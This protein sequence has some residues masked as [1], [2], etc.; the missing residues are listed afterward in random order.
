MKQSFFEMQD[1]SKRLYEL[2]SE[3]AKLQIQGRDA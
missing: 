1:A 3:V 2:E